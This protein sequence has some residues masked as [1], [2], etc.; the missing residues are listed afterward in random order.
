MNEKRWIWVPYKL[1]NDGQWWENVYFFRIG[2]TNI[3]CRW[4]ILSLYVRANNYI[5]LT[6]WMKLTMWWGEYQWGWGSCTPPVCLDTLAAAT[7]CGA[8]AGSQVE[9]EGATGRRSALCLG[10]GEP[11]GCWTPTSGSGNSLGERMSK[12]ESE[13]LSWSF[14]EISIW[15]KFCQIGVEDTPFMN[16]NL[17]ICGMTLTNVLLPLFQLFWN[18]LHQIQNE[19]ITKKNLNY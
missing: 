15:S 18:R 1:F 13:M 2:S 3:Q 5:G 6:L 10:H 7:P 11:R 14:C 19:S 4:K 9:L 17:F 16:L 8:P 12:D